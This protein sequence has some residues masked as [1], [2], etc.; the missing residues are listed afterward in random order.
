MWLSVRWRGCHNS[1]DDRVQTFHVAKEVIDRAELLVVEG[2]SYVFGLGIQVWMIL[3][4]SA[5][6]SVGAGLG[7]IAA[8]SSK[9]IQ[10]QSGWDPF[11]CCS[12]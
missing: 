1:R 3:P 7:V 5:V 9:F 2:D 12:Y 4:Q 11:V 8:T 6:Q 10:A